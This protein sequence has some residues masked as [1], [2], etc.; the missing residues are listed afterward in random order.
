[1]SSAPSARDRLLLA[2]AEL[3]Y[4]Q[5]VTATGVDA[6]AERA[7]VTK[8]TLYVRFGSKDA[9]VTEA[10]RVRHEPML[11]LLREKTLRR[12]TRADRPPA[13]AYFDVL[14]RLFASAGWRGCAFLNA[15]AEVGDPD[16][17][18]H[19]VVAEHLAGRRA[20]IADLLGDRG[21]LAPAVALVGEGAF[22]VSAVVRGPAP[23]REARAAVERLL[24]RAA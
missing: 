4:E 17:P 6:I 5:G 18:L 14:E 19:A 24:S 7:G 16:H 9:L 11:A 22:A 2:A 23:A 10:L 3:T 8:R 12:A 15:S 1:V 21:E 20:L 13:L